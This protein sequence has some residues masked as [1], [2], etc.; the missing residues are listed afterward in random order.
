MSE[1]GALRQDGKYDQAGALYEQAV[2][3]ATAASGANSLIVAKLLHLRGLALMDDGKTKLALPLLERSVRIIEQKHGPS[4]E[5]I[6]PLSAKAETHR[7][8]GQRTIA[9]RL[10]RRSVAL[11]ER[12]FGP[13]H[14]KT[15]E[16]RGSAS[17][18]ALGGSE[19]DWKEAIHSAEKRLKWS[20]KQYGEEHLETALIQE[21]LGFA[22]TAKFVSRY[23]EAEDLLLRSLKTQRKIYGPKHYQVVNPLATLGLLYNQMRRHEEALPLFRESIEIGTRRALIQR[24]FLSTRQESTI[25]RLM[26]DRYLIAATEVSQKYLATG[27]VEKYKA[28]SAEAFRTVQWAKRPAAAAAF[29]AHASRAV[30]E[31]ESQAELIRQGQDLANRW[32][33]MDR[34]RAAA[35]GSGTWQ[36]LSRRQS[37]IERQIKA[38]TAKLEKSAAFRNYSNLIN[39]EPMSVSAVRKLLRPEEALVYFYSTGSNTAVWLVGNNFLFMHMLPGKNSALKKLVNTL[40]CGLDFST[41]NKAADINV[42]PEDDCFRLL[43][44]A[45]EV[46][47]LPF[48]LDLAYKLYQMIFGDDVVEQF[49]S[50]LDLVVVPD[51]PVS[52]LPLQVLVTEPPLDNLTDNQGY[53]EVEWLGREKA[54]TVLPAVSSLKALRFKEKFH[55]GRRSYL[56]FGNPL[57]LGPD[58]NDRRAWKKQDCAPAKVAGSTAVTAKRSLPPNARRQR[59]FRGGGVDLAAFKRVAPLP[60]TADELC[61]VA[62]YLGA[63]PTHSVRL[64]R[65]ATETEVKKLSK[66]GDLARAHIVH[67]ATHGLLP[68]ETETLASKLVEPSLMLTPPDH[69]SASDDG[70]LTTS[71][72]ATLKM[73]AEWVILSACNTGASAANDND[74]MSGLASAFIHAGANALLV[75]HWYVDSQATVRLVTRAVEALRDD[76]TMGHSRALKI[77]MTDLIESGDRFAHPSNWAPFTVVGEGGADW[78]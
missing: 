10:F 6:A 1:A 15:V 21:N 46:D 12:I 19:N 2:R 18:M 72:I 37:E 23:E 55:A 77:A 78:R 13:D 8:L 61:A 32:H 53:S 43:N 68:L 27:N 20:L 3:L 70:L 42:K 30:L 47:G 58:E 31:D 26:F 41:W 49:M 11:A 5:L 9:A 60:E 56:G 40:R 22:Y 50:D 65:K 66:T 14:P 62:R 28:V 67:F 35:T 38:L 44:T 54:I 74:A 59:L 52:A 36:K 64:G 16:A 4:K 69:V 39:P 71:E 17:L 76:P 57:L 51:G 75:S 24:G 33:Q 45:P 25:S 34:E 63:E 29:G 48:R 73:N 7:R